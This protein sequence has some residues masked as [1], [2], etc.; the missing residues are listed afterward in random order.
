MWDIQQQYA[1]VQKTNLGNQVHNDEESTIREPLLPRP[2]LMKKIDQLEVPAV[3][4]QVY[5]AIVHLRRARNSLRE[6]FRQDAHSSTSQLLITELM[7]MSFVVSSKPF[8]N[9]RII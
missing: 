8:L 1:E 7:L 6:P 2:S 4:S 3:N 5:N 9:F